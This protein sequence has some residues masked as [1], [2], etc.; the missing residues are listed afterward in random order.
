MAEG[1]YEYYTEG[2]AGGAG[3][4]GDVRVGNAFTIGTVGPNED[5]ILSSLKLLMYRQGNPGPVLYAEIYACANGLPTGNVLSS[6]SLSRDNIKSGS[7]F[8]WHIIAMS[9]CKLKASTKYV[10]VIYSTGGDINNRYWIRIY[11]TPPYLGGDAFYYDELGWTVD[12]SFDCLFEIWGGPITEG[13][14]ELTGVTAPTSAHEGDPINL[15]VH[16]K[17][18]GAA[19]DFRVE[20]LALG[21]TT[22][23]EFY[24]DAAEPKDVLFFFT[25]PNYD[26]SITIN[27]YHLTEEGDWVWDVTSVWDVNRWQ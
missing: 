16:T 20:L 25:M 8:E 4:Y 15:M 24:L 17:N 13:F 7:P 23:G 26:V 11:N 9:P 12:P 21:E 3:F 18:T 1:L 2:T 19:D 10:W 5:F 27:T 14:L 6:G 22:A